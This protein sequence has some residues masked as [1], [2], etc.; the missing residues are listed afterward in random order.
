MHYGSKG[1]YVEKLK[2]AGVRTYEGRKVEKYKK[3]VLAN[4]LEKTK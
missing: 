2:E 1:W 3:F 4:L